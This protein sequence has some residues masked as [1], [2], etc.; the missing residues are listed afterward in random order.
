MAVSY[1][2]KNYVV[3][4]TCN[5]TNAGGTW[6]G[7]QAI[8]S[9]VDNPFVYGTQSVNFTTRTAAT[10]TLNFAPSSA[11][12]M[13]TGSPVIRLWFNSFQKF[14][15]KASNGLRFYIG[16]S[17]NTAYWQITGGDLYQGGWICIVV[18]TGT[19]QDAG[20]KPTM[21]AVTKMGIEAITVGTTKNTP[22]TFIDHLHR[23]D[24]MN[25]YGNVST[26]VPFGFSNLQ[27][28]DDT[29]S[30]KWGFIGIY[31]TIYFANHYL[32]VGDSAGSNDC[33]FEVTD[34]TF[35]FDNSIVTNGAFTLEFVENTGT[36]SAILT[37]TTLKGASINFD[38]ICDN[39][40]DTLEFYQCSIINARIA[41]FD[42]SVVLD[43]TSFIGC[44][45]VSIANDPDSCSFILSGLITISSGGTL[46]SCLINSSTA[47]SAV[48]VE[49][50][51]DLDA[52][53]FV[54]DG[55]GHAINLGTVSTT[56]SMTW[57]CIDS[58]YASSDGSTGNET[59]LVSVASGQTLTI[60]VAAGKTSPSV[61]N[62]GSGSVSVLSGQV[63]LEV[64]VKAAATGSVI[65]GARVYVEAAS[66]G[67]LSEGTAVISGTLTDAQGVAS[68]TRSYASNQPITG[69]VRKSSSSPYYRTA[70]LAGT[71]N[72][73]SGLSVTV[74]MIKDE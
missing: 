10:Q 19:T 52:C 47:S 46:T 9:D 12:N 11:V 20:T 27:V 74:Q 4:S 53:I 60:N 14:A 34:Q 44:G 17:S 49:D 62:T 24:G 39:A 13:T 71:I 3:L 66:G 57:N 48:S 30:T 26:G 18:D 56:T 50:L 37:R 21:S 41:N 73:S 1:T 38:L 68:D 55:T 32:A 6:T 64:T 70:P 33:L 67:P 28:I 7:G 63:T 22:S 16:D 45:T 8:T 35:V 36:T 72:S 25:V 65:E 15:V 58:G 31:N 61:Y 42:S 2:L 54:S 59:I 51:T 40:I 43:N 23:G 29:T 5:A 69:W